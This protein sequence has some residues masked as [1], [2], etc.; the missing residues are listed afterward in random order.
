MFK[1]ELGLPDEHSP[2]EEKA[3]E[4]GQ[5]E[6]VFSVEEEAKKK[7]DAEAAARL[8]AEREKC[9]EEDREELEKTYRRF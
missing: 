3:D 8:A 6:L 2:K 7:A 9:R 4:Y 5:Y 1:P